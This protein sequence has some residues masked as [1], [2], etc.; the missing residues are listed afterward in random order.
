MG[1]S[2]RS[3]S[4]GE[5]LPTPKSFIAPGQQMSTPT[6]PASRI[7]KPAPMSDRIV[8]RTAD[9]ETE[10]GRIRNREAS[11]KIRDAW[12]YKQI[13]ARQVRPMNLM[14]LVTHS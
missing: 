7:G 12:I 10:D 13:R 1:S 3:Q 14:F 5:F 2:S 8:T 11:Q 4:A 6:T 9:E